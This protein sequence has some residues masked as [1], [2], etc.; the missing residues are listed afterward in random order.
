MKKIPITLIYSRLVIGLI[1]IVLSIKQVENYRFIAVALLT[2]GLLT[3][4]FDGIIARKLAISTQTLRR[5]DSTV[6]Q[7]FF[8]AVA[9][10]TYI[11]HPGFFQTNAVKL[12]T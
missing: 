1:L 3:D 11:Q 2:I 5:L 6:D 10:A 4:I 8:L 12:L 7:V 9:V